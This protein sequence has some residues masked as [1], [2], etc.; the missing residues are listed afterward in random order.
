MKIVWSEACLGRGDSG[1]EQAGAEL[2][3]AHFILRDLTQFEFKL[4]S[5]Y[6]SWDFV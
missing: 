1:Q 5:A 4:R 2:S 3:W 6:S